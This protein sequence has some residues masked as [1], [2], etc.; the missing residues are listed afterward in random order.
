MVKISG[1]VITF[2]EEKN[3]GRCLESLKDVADELVVVDSL[4]TDRTEEI[5]RQYNARFI[6]QPFLGYVDQKAF[7]AEQAKYDFVL[8]LDADEALSEELKKSILAVKE[9]P[10]ADAYQFNRYNN[11][12]GK[13]LRLG[14]FY[15][16][17]KIRLWNRTKGA[18]E[19]ENIHEKVIMRKGS[20]IKRLRG[21]ILHYAY[22]TLD[23]HL[24]QMYK[25]SLIAAQGKF[26][27]GR[28]HSFIMHVLM[29]PL[30]K[31]VKKYIF[32]GGFLYGYY[33]FVF[34]ATAAAVNFF[35]Y[36]R[37]YEYNRLKKKPLDDFNDNRPT[38]P[39]GAEGSG[40]EVSRP[41]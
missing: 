40:G 14:G 27:R 8:S 34:C 32:Q 38:L 2:N 4:S 11:Y 30:F 19:G 41:S 31:F 5:C 7:A 35:K 29:S 21:D 22:E 36:L 28:R 3:I 6:K 24:E 39:S 33:G 9:N 12:C 13:W 10:D 18:W 16:D 17:R 1:V 26:Q 37:L 25:F 15:P 23:Q 20:I